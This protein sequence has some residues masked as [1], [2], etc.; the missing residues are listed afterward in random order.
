MSRS[1]QPFLNLLFS[2]FFRCEMNG[3]LKKSTYPWTTIQSD[4]KGMYMMMVM[5]STLVY[6]ALFAYDVDGFT[7]VIS[8]LINVWSMDDDVKDVEEQ[9]RVCV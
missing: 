5:M 2:E 7:L 1:D 4:D 8:D 6:Y 9:H 3:R